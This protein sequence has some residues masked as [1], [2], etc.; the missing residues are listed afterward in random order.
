MATSEVK[1]VTI[2]C[3]LC[4]KNINPDLSYINAQSYG[5]D[6]HVHCAD[7]HKSILKALGL[8]DIKRM[9]SHDDWGTATK[10]IYD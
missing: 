6:F 4:G 2:V 7:P 3:D 8:D 1:T 5:A 10:Y 9:R